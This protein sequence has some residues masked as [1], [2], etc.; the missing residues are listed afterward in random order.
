MRT[1]EDQIKDLASLFIDIWDDCPYSKEAATE[2]ILE[3][4]HRAE[5]RVRTEIGRDSE[6]LDWLAETVSSIG[7]RKEEPLIWKL[8]FVT[9]SHVSDPR[10]IRIA[11]DAARENAND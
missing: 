11:I 4:E 10:K 8:I 5:Q 6:R 2:H 7:G 3:A 1:R 9:R